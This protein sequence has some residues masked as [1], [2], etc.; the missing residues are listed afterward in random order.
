MHEATSKKSDGSG[1]DP[2][3]PVCRPR[4]PNFDRLMRYG[5][6]IDANRFYTNF[7][8]MHDLLRQ[9]LSELF[10]IDECCIAL[11]NSGT[12]ALTALL[13]AAAGHASALRPLCVCAD[14]TFA[15]TAA[16]AVNCGYKPYLVDV[17]PVT[18]ALDPTVIASLPLLNKVG[19]V[20]VTAPLG[21]MVD[22]QAWQAFSE[23]T[24]IPVI[25]DAAACFDTLEPAALCATRLPLMISM[26]ATKTFSTCEG[27]LMLCADT[28]LIDR[29]VS[30]TNFGFE[31]ERTSVRHGVN[32]KMSEYH[33]MI[34]L[35]ELDEWEE[36]RDGFRRAG[37]NYLALARDL[38]LEGQV[39]A[40]GDHALPYAHFLSETVEQAE[41]ITLAL[42]A[43][44]IGWRRWYGLGLRSQRAFQKYP[45]FDLPKAKDLA[46]RLISLPMA[47]D[48]QHE[49]IQRTL[50]TV[51]AVGV[52]LEAICY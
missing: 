41:R 49:E 36:K 1:C 12:T 6:A 3:I 50:E 40:D 45:A 51:D 16:A 43:N 52:E 18:W 13:Q 27:G 24:R 29:A 25:V 31:N 11:A 20:I 46:F 35:A 38:G 34:G 47:V 23:L 28:A 4:L 9:R 44:Y 5:D 10:S 22:L 32:G 33:A 15:A 14:F 21:R 2:L 42:D 48:L 37:A 8:A 7:G 39:H 26:H 17:H 19:A 30:V